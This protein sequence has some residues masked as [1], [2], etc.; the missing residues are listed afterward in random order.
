[1]GRLVTTFPNSNEL[2]RMKALL[3]ERRLPHEVISPSPAYDAVGTP[4]LVADPEVR[5]ALAELEGR[6]FVTSGWVDYRPSE[7]GVPEKEPPAFEEDVFGRAS[8]MVL[9]PCVA[10]PGKIRIIA[11][12][13]EDM[14]GA[15]PYLNA[16]TPHASY[17]PNG[18]HLTLMEDGRVITL[19]P[20]RIAAARAD[21]IVDAWRLLED[22]RCRVNGVWARRSEVEPSYEMR[23]RPPALEMSATN[24]GVVIHIIVPPMRGYFMPSISVIFVLN[25]AAAPFSL[26][27]KGCAHKDRRLTGNRRIVQK[28]RFNNI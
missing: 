21:E 23:E 10:E 2:A 6:S 20:R 22:I 11:H 12:V 8:V 13:S 25:M 1:M 4:S 24:S 18:P 14:G 16:V 28:G 27:I 7:A 17:N 19:Y 15:F 3:D 5:M 26:D 9:A